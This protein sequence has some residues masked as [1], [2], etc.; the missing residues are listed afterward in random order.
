MFEIIKKSKETRARKG[1]MRTAHGEVNT[2]VFMPVATQGTVKTVSSEELKKI[3]THLFVSNAYHLYL[4]PGAKLINSAG[5]LHKYINWDRSILTDS[6]GFQVYSLSTLR[7]ITKEGVKFQSHIDGSSHLF[8]PESVMDLQM[9]LGSD[10][11]MCFDECVPYP[12]TYEYAKNS[13][14]MTIDWAKRCKKQFVESKTERVNKKQFLFGIVQGSTYLDLRKESALRTIEIDFDGYALGGLAV[15]EPADI[16]NE[17]VV[18]TA[19]LLPEDK[20]RYAMGVGTPEELWA[21][22]E[23]GIDVFDCVLPSRNGRNGQALTFSGKVN[24]RNA[25]YSNDFGP[26]DE[27]C[28]C[29]VC[30]EYSRSFIHHL[31]R[32]GEL[33][34]L[35]LLT[36]HNLFFMLKLINL[37]STSIDEDNFL[38]QKE[39]FFDKYKGNNR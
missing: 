27:G 33:L 29:P 24:I 23:N 32:S 22:I 12:S 37:I 2:P 31:F 13:M 11:M 3:G 7:K 18:N 16:T 35:R 10:I 20:P 4:R 28:S 8:T 6:G 30:T 19:P 15:G 17:I 25:Q 38:S 26:L 9:E 5:G 36:L 34:S 14:E 1:I 21:Y 39:K